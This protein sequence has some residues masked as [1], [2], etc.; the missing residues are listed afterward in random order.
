MAKYHFTRIPQEDIFTRCGITTYAVDLDDA[1]F[2]LA[3]LQNLH[4]DLGMFIRQ[5]EEGNHE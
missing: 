1:F 4:R 2:T 5:E 3:E